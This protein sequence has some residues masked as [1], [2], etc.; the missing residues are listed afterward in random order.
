[1]ARVRHMS[2]R[3][4]R[5]RCSTAC[6][7][8]RTPPR[9]QAPD[10]R[11]ALVGS[12]TLEQQA[13]R[14]DISAHALQDC[15]ISH[16]QQGCRSRPIAQ[17]S[18]GQTD[19]QTILLDTTA[20]QGCKPCPTP[21]AQ[22]RGGSAHAGWCA[23]RVAHRQLRWMRHRCSRAARLLQSPGCGC[24]PPLE[25]LVFSTCLLQ[26][27]WHCAAASAEAVELHHEAQAATPW[28][29]P[30]WRRRRL[31]WAAA[32]PSG[33]RAEVAYDQTGAL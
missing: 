4:R 17:Q 28:D 14:H 23:A 25:Q 30:A 31:R 16:A 10:P 24:A 13:P 32:A 27:R 11:A 12:A 15:C 3:S 22:Q 9:R 2:T 6:S 18:G 1:M 20:Q 8:G 5:L 33:R 26:R 7:A 21:A 19:A 29:R